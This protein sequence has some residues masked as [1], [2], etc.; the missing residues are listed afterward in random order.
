MTRTEAINKLSETYKPKPYRLANILAN[1]ISPDDILE[2]IID[3]YIELDNYTEELTDTIAY[4]KMY[5]KLPH[6]KL[7]SSCSKLYDCSIRKVLTNYELNSLSL[8]LTEEQ[9]PFGC[10]YHTTPMTM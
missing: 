2:L 1:V 7:C 4:L 3:E 5:E 10:E 9:S 6:Q 8:C